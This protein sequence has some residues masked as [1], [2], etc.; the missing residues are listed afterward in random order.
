METTIGMVDDSRPLVVVTTRFDWGYW[1]Y[2][3]RVGGIVRA[4]YRNLRAA[5]EGHDKVVHAVLAERSKN[6]NADS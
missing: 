4:K 3:V 2:L 5:Q 6:R 1:G